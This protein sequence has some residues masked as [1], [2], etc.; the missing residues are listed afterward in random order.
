MTWAWRNREER[1]ARR[2]VCRSRRSPFHSAR[3]QLEVLEDRM[4]PSANILPS[5]HLPGQRVLAQNDVLFTAGSFS[6]PQANSWIAHVDYG[7]GTGTQSLPLQPDHS[8]ILNHTYASEGTFELSVILEDN[9]GEVALAKMKVDAESVAG[10]TLRTGI[11]ILPPAS[12]IPGSTLSSNPLTPRPLPA[13]SN[14]GNVIG[15]LAEA[16]GD[17]NLTLVKSDLIDAQV[18]REI[19]VVYQT[20]DGPANVRSEAPIL[21]KLQKTKPGLNRPLP[22]KSTD[23]IP[24]LS[25]QPKYDSAQEA[26]PARAS[27]QEEIKKN[28]RILIRLQPAISREDMALRL[29]AKPRPGNVFLAVVVLG[30][31]IKRPKF[32][33]RRARNRSKNRNR[34]EAPANRGMFM[35]RIS[36]ARAPPLL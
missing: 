7:D 36:A 27:E 25:D 24:G 12:A 32:R 6:D 1:N 23:G 10:V 18:A 35:E 14:T 31:G 8:F 28:I 9:Q 5:I 20:G 16:S 21:E 13:M 4:A 17:D 29:L 11:P 33:K 3:P 30:C 34:P 15:Y 2:H 26:K 22:N 19:P